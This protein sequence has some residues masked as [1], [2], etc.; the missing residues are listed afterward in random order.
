M[1]IKGLG[2]LD[3][4][5]AKKLKTAATSDALN[6]DQKRILRALYGTTKS[7]PLRGEKLVE[8][9]AKTMLENNYADVVETLQNTIGTRI[10]PQ[11]WMGKEAIVKKKWNFWIDWMINY[12]KNQELSS[13]NSSQLSI[14]DD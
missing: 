8:N 9:E 4:G 10:D 14:V 3:R 12:L 11:V 7:I 6:Y 2:P 5:I 13:F 1:K